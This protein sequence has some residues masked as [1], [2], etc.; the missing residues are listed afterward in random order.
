MVF[1][2]DVQVAEERSDVHRRMPPLLVLLLPKF[3]FMSLCC[4]IRTYKLAFELL[5]QVHLPHLQVLST[6]RNHGRTREEVQG[7]VVAFLHP[8]QYSRIDMRLC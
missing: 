2:A 6:D 7:T 4:C 3:V 8:F 5:L 1:D